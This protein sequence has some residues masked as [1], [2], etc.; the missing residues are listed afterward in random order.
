MKLSTNAIFV[1]NVTYELIT[2]EIAFV[3]NI[4]LPTKICHYLQILDID[5][6]Q[7]SCSVKYSVI[8]IFQIQLI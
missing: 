6:D 1:D 3:D 7:I 8:V 5:N 4:K 2:Y